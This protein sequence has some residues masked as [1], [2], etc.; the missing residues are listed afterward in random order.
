MTPSVIALQ[1]SLKIC[2]DFALE[3]NVMFNCKKTICMRV[4]SDGEPPERAV[5]L[6]GHKLTWSKKV[7]HLGNIVTHDLR[8]LED[9]NFKTG[10]FIS[11]VNKLKCK[12]CTVHSTLRGRLL[13]T[14]CCS[15]HGC[16]TWDLASGSVGRMNIEWNKAVRRTLL[17]PYKTR[18]CLL[19]L[20]VQGKPFVV[21]H[22]S[23]ISNFLVSF[24]ESDN[25]RVFYIGERAK[26]YSHGALG[27]NYTRCRGHVEIDPAS[28]D[29]VARASAIRELMDVRD[30]MSV[31]PGMSPDDIDTM[32]SFI[33]CH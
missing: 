25:S 12:F 7:K 17:L 20:L 13:Q 27:R 29:L 30:G 28:T 3:Y 8:D 31:L 15:W 22:R 10:V 9:I 14:Y 23:R 32:I 18:T 21:Q 1:S 11:Q 2:E 5:T 33:S 6:N 16:Q 4:G 19:P 26:T 24:T